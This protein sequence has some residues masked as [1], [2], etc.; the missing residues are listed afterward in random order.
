MY[1]PPDIN[2]NIIMI[3]L[4]VCQFYFFF[5]A[6]YDIIMWFSLSGKEGE[7]VG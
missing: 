1:N 5:M 3:T 7:L 4:L 6:H 2:H